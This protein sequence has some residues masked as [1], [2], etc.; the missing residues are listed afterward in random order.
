M[1]Q[2]AHATQRS[3][4]DEIARLRAALEAIVAESPNDT[5]YSWCQSKL[6]RCNEIAG[7]ALAG[8]PPYDKAPTDPHHGGK[9]TAEQRM[10]SLRELVHYLGSRAVL[11]CDELQDED[12]RCYL[13]STN[14]ADVLRKMKRSYDEYRMQTGDMGDED[15]LSE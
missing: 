7:S 10:R 2:G 12:D 4:V 8:A 1:I 15:A 3:L 11:V 6:A 5:A 14:H 9:L 13:G